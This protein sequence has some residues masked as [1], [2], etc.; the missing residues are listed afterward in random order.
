MY[1]FEFRF[2]WIVLWKRLKKR[3]QF[4]AQIFDH[5]EIL[6][7]NVGIFAKWSWELCKEGVIASAPMT[8]SCISYARHKTFY[9]VWNAAS[10]RS[11]ISTSIQLFIQ[12]L[13]G[14]AARPGTVDLQKVLNCAHRLTERRG[15]SKRSFVLSGFCQLLQ[16]ESLDTTHSSPNCDLP[17]PKSFYILCWHISIRQAY[18]QKVQ[19]MLTKK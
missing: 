19:K 12:A 1:N 7:V 18:I 4:S 14:E 17:A 10:A 6:L 13:D 8:I 16:N 9:N 3:P 15:G 5:G 2:L 11:I